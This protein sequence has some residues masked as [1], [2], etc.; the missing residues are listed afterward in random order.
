[1]EEKPPAY[2]NLNVVEDLIQPAENQDQQFN[3]NNEQYQQYNGQQQQQNNG[4]QQQPYYGQP[5]QQYNGPPQ[6]QY[7]GP[8]Q[9]YNGT[10]QQQYNGPQ[11]QQYNGPQP[12][13]HNEMDEKKQRRLRCMAI[14]GIVFGS[15]GLE[16]VAIIL[17]AMAL[18]TY[19]HERGENC[20]YGMACASLA[21][22]LVSCLL[23]PLVILYLGGFFGPVFWAGF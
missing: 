5:Q 23:L 14:S 12:R 15:L 21:L 19:K 9:Q 22:G 3:Q 13:Q 10:Q 17:G 6:Q 20:S 4:Q 8:Q 16:L 1:M 18:A 2:D 11:Q 7:N